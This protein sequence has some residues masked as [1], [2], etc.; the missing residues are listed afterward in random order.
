MRKL[1]VTE[2][3]GCPRAYQ[4]TLEKVEKLPPNFYA[5]R[6]TMVHLVLEEY[7]REIVKGEDFT[8]EVGE[9]QKFLALFDEW[10]VVKDSYIGK[11]LMRDYF[12]LCENIQKWFNE[13][14]LDVSMGNV[15]AVEA[16]VMMPVRGEYYLVGHFDVLTKTH[17]IDFKSGKTFRNYDYVKQLGAYR[18]LSRYMGV[19]D[20]SLNGDFDLVNVFFGG[21]GFGEL[22]WSQR[23]VDR[24]MPDFY[25]SFFGLVEEDQKWREDKDYMMPCR[26][27][28]KC[29]FCDFRGNPCRSA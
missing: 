25:S 6:G 28:T 13:S 1:R 10:G 16:E 18:D 29:A 5:M 12:K 20:E 7:F 9:L 21:D 17:I 19:H 22:R 24:V 23:D 2:I 4:Y 27:S 3:L 11:R 26:L 14:K 15:L 8:Y